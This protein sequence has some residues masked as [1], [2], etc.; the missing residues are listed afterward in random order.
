MNWMTQ[1]LIL[2]K[3][4]QNTLSTFLNQYGTS[5]LKQALKMYT[6]LQQQYICKTKTSISSFK[7]SDIYYLEIHGHNI[8]VHTQHG[9]YHK[10]GT[11]NNEL[12]ILSPYGFVKCT[13]SIIVSLQKVRTINHHDI[14]LINNVTI[15]MSRKFAPSVLMSFSYNKK[16]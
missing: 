11:L 12:K 6:D 15:P 9:V 5:G 2:T 14:I 7:I 16:K 10:Y 3:D 13:Q 1:E 4:I 8:S